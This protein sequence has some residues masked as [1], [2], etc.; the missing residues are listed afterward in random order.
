VLNNGDLFVE[1]GR[2]GSMAQSKLHAIANVNAATK[3]LN[4]LVKQKQAKG[5]HV[6]TNAD[7]SEL[8]YDLLAQGELIRDEIQAIQDLWRPMEPFSLIR[9]HPESGQ[10][11]SPLGVL[12]LETVSIAQARLA[13]VQTYYRLGREEFI[14]AVEAYLRV[15]PIPVVGKLDAQ[16]LLGSRTQLEQQERLLSNLAEGLRQ[17][18]EIHRW[19]Q[20]N[21][22]AGNRSAWL[23][24]GTV[25]DARP[26]EFTD[27]GRSIAIAWS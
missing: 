24:W 10:F 20:T 5:Y 13:T 11:R 9:F 2:V 6:V 21:L 12:S 3:K 26:T 25:P 7:S 4:I 17:V 14:P 27:D 18:G 22:N 16:V 15:I 23:S 8:D 19:I 1:Y